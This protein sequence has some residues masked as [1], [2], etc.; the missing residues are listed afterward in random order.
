MTQSNSPSPQTSS[1]MPVKVVAA[2][3]LLLCIAGGGLLYWQHHPIHR[4]HP[5][6]VSQTR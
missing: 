4:L 6:H 2:I 5:Y 1:N 3:V